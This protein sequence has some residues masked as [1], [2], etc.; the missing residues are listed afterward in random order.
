[1]KVNLLKQFRS[2]R[3]V[4]IRFRPRVNKYVV[5]I[6]GEM[7]SPKGWETIWQSRTFDTFG[8]ALRRSHEVIQKQ[9]DD[10]KW[11]IGYAAEKRIYP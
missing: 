7:G 11:N 1:M 9:V 6:E 5:E 8:L 3:G 10:L 2:A 4:E